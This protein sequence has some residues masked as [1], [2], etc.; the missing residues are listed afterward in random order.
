M[1][2]YF[3]QLPS[4]LWAILSSLVQNFVRWATESRAKAVQGAANILSAIGSG[5]AALPGRVA[6]F[7]SQVISR[8]ASWVSNLAAKG[9]EAASRVITSVTSGLKSLPGKMLSIGL[10]VA[11]GIGQGITNGTQWIKNKITE[12]VGDV[13]AFIKRVFKIGSPSRLMADEVGK[14]I[15]AGIGVGITDNADSA[16]DALA[17]M[18]D[19][20]MDAANP[21]LGGLSFERE[22]NYTNKING[23]AGAM[24]QS[25]AALLAK[26]DGIYERLGRLQVVLDSGATVGG[27]IDGIDSALST[28]QILRARGV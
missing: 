6:S 3:S 9:R 28:R 16:T 14:W 7:L 5:L 4:K 20:M 10:D 1:K 12:L 25:N 18:S 24:A 15:P 2:N 26:L 21:E 19:D 8:M 17:A 22:L 27:L 23:P 11:K 13:V